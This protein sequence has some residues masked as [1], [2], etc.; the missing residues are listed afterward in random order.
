MAS[1]QSCADSGMRQA[2]QDAQQ[3]AASSQLPAQQAPPSPLRTSKPRL[4][5]GTAESRP[6]GASQ[7]I[8]VPG[9]QASYSENLQG[10]LA[11]S[12]V[13]WR[14]SSPSY[15]MAFD[16]HSN[17]VLEYCSRLPCLQGG[18]ALPA[19]VFTSKFT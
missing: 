16:L 12:Q 6:P 7:Q 10:V 15:A 8:L 5:G 13:W 18:H 19:S 11:D 2:L 1:A 3:R 14:M 4:T 9:M 17:A